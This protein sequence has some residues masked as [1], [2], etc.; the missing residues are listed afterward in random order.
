MS[1]ARRQ[2]SILAA[3]MAMLAVVLIWTFAQQRHLVQRAAKRSEQAAG[4]LTA[5]L[6]QETGLRGYALAHRESFLEPYVEGRSAYTA[7]VR[8]LRAAV[9]GDRRSERAFAEEQDL[10][11]RWQAAAST[12]IAA[13]REGRSAGGVKEAEQRKAL[14]DGFR[15]ANGQLRDRLTARRNLDLAHSARLSIAAVL[16]MVLGCGLT[17][18]WLITRSARRHASSEETGYRDGQREFSDVIQVVDSEREAH[19]LIKRH[20]ERSIRGA[21]TTV[22]TRNNS[23]N[24]LEAVTALADDDWLISGL[25]HAEPTDC[26]AIRLA[27][28]HT[29]EAGT[30]PLLSCQVCGGTPGSSSCSPL[31][32]GGKV[33]GSVLVEHPSVLAEDESRS[34]L[35][36]LAQAGPV[37]GNLRTI[38]IAESRAAT[39][40]LTGLANRRAAQDVLKRMVAHASRAGSSLAAVA[41]DLDH[42]KSI[43]DRF[44]HDAGDSVLAAVGVAISAIIR[45]SDFVARM[46]GEEFLVLAPDTDRTGAIALAETLREAIA[47]ER[48]DSLPEAVTASL[49]VAVLPADAGNADLLLRRADRAL[50]MAKERGRNRVET[51]AR[52]SDRAVSADGLED[53]PLAEAAR[54]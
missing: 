14:M 27:R 31:L 46:G 45:E 12:A 10:A 40:V 50:Y 17:G 11:E 53:A 5:M 8:D 30:E 37:L 44:G 43:N 42:F 23:D 20:L 36:S 32:I 3:V 39:D 6:D 2:F 41:I 28:V 16:L 35:D 33:I 34:L 4:L 38:A 49:G 52:E 48:T 1:L 26:I 51:V 25:E 22:L 18:G 21:R 47:R 19:R 7:T 24:R 9:A 15:A 29:E 54:E 13:V